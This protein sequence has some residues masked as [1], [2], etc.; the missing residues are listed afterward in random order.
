MPTRDTGEKKLALA[1]GV[2]SNIKA[3]RLIRHLPEVEAVH[4][5]PHMGDGGWRSARRSHA[6]SRPASASRSTFAARLGPSL[7]A[8]EIERR[9]R[10]EGVAL[11]APSTR[12]VDAVADLIAE[13]AMVMWFQGRM[14]YGPRALGP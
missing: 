14:E 5:F 2:A 4:V 8:S 7:T 6:R 3:T 10:R 12:I 13:G 1:G 9:S 11:P